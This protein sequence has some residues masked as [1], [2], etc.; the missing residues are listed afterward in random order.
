MINYIFDELNILN[1]TMQHVT[2]TANQ[3]TWRNACKNEYGDYFGLLH[4]YY[5]VDIKLA[6]LWRHNTPRQR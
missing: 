3:G 2:W 4:G 1:T 5:I 6:Q